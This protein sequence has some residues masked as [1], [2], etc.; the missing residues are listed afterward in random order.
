MVGSKK[1]RNV[2]YTENK[3]NKKQNRKWK[4]ICLVMVLV[5][6]FIYYEVYVL[7]NYT[8]GREVTETQ[9]SLYKWIVSKV[10][11]E[12][13]LN[14]ATD[15][16]IA[17]L[18]NIKVRGELLESYSYNGIV[19]YS[20]IFG[21]LSFEEYDYTIASLNTSIVLDAKP[22]GNFYANSKLIK[23]LKNINIDMLVTANQE[24]GTQKDKVIEETLKEVRNHGLDYIGASINNT[25][26]PYYILDKNN[27]KIAILAYV[28]EIYTDNDSLNIYSKKQLKAD[29]KEA[30]KEKVDG[31]IV[32]IDTLR[33]NHK[34]AKEEK[35][36]ILQ[37]ILDEGADIVISN[38]IVEQKLYKNSEKTKYIKYSLGD[39]IGLQETEGSDVSKVLNISVK[40]E[41]KEG[42]KNISFQV[43]EDKT[44]VALSNEDM[45]KY[46]VVDLDEE[47]L[48][49]D[50]TSDK[51]SVAEYSY[52]KKVKESIK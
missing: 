4:Y 19:D 52:L 46:K 6:V 24:L 16:D 12:E 11:K 15:I 13:I 38:D 1:R 35:K 9:I 23:E 8:I 26:Y 48:N 31:I 44:L 43:D 3:R 33:S 2:E 27:I 45:T 49:F 36:K 41:Y 39:V 47:I 50:E 14:K 29:I 18:G 42:K 25:N 34:N 32:F 21:N 28:D 22:E 51:I 40:K 20:N 30:K 17:V 37:E 10:N 5:T 7:V